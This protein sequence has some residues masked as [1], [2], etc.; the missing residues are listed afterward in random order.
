M[1]MSRTSVLEKYIHASHSSALAT[2]TAVR[3]TQK[4]DFFSTQSRRCSVM[5]YRGK[6]FCF[7]MNQCC[8]VAQSDLITLIPK[9]AATPP[10]TRATSSA[11]RGNSCS[12]TF[13]A[14]GCA[15]QTCT[16]LFLESHGC[17]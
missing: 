13:A 5:Y 10:L 14:Q 2:I 8:R 6:R 9:Y 16:Q 15:E 4:G 11:L 3:F 1:Q 12:L 17:N 7:Y